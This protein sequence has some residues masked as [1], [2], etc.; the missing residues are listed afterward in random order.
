M[1]LSSG[2]L[3]FMVK[4]TCNTF[5]SILYYK[6]YYRESIL[7]CGAD[8]LSF[9]YDGHICGYLTLWIALPTKYK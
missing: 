9:E 8:I 6:L 4:F 5:L 2:T 7:F 1:F 3:L